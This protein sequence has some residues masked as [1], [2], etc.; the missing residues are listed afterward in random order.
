MC[1]AG[2]GLGREMSPL[3][4]KSPVWGLF[5]LIKC[6][7]CAASCFFIRKKKSI[8]QQQQA[9]MGKLHSSSQV[10]VFY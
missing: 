10:A 3:H 6:R 9:E 1:P 8:F 4:A 7:F 2:G 5:E